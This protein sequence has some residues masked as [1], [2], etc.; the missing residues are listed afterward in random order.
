MCVR[1]GPA[2]FPLTVEQKEAIE[3]SWE[4]LTEVYKLP[5]DQ[6]YVTYFEGDPKNGLE[7]DLEAKQYWL[8]TGVAE[9]HIIPGNAKD[10]FWGTSHGCIHSA[11]FTDI[12]RDGCNWSLWPLQVSVMMYCGIRGA[13][14]Q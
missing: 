10:N 6:L 9:D 2:I 12:H 4:L 7:P 11:I 14:V 13:C 3:Y 5:K 8:S 1:P